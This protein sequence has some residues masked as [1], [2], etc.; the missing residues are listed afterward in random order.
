M[1]RLGAV[2]LAVH[3]ARAVFHR[4]RA[5]RHLEQLTGTVLFGLGTAVAV[6]TTR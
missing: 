4:P 1:V 5:R 2:A 6:E 3:R